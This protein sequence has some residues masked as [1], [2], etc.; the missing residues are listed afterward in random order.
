MSFSL[1]MVACVKFEA[2]KAGLQ[3]QP[4]KV[5]VPAPRPRGVPEASGLLRVTWLVVITVIVLYVCL[6][7][8]HHLSKVSAEMLRT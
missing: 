1:E 5:T 6:V 8:V 2:C 4:A 3:Y 7:N